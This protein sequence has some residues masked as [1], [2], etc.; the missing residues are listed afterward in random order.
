VKRKI[1]LG[2]L[3][4]MHQPY[5]RDPIDDIYILP[6]VRLHAVNAYYTMP[7]FASRFDKLHTNFNLVPSLIEQLEDYA[8]GR[9][10]DLYERYSRLAPDALDPAAKA[11]IL[12]NFFMANWETMIRPNTRYNDLLLKRGFQ[13]HETRLDEVSRNFTNQDFT[14]LQTW[15]N[16][17]WIGPAAREENEDIGKLLRKGRFF[18]QEE[19][20]LVLDYHYDVIRKVLPAYRE[21]A[22]QGLAELNL[23]PFYHPI[24]PLLCDSDIA[25]EA[26]PGVKLPERFSHQEDAAR[27]IELG[28]E[29]FER[30]LGRRPEGMWPSEGS[31]SRAVAS[32]ASEAGLKW[33]ATDEE[34]LMKS[35]P[36][37]PDR[38]D[39]IHRPYKI[40]TE[41]GDIAIFFR[42]KNLSDLLG[43]T[44]ARNTPEAAV[45]DFISHLERISEAAEKKK[46]EVFVSV[47]LD[48]ENPW[49]YY[50]NNGADFLLR[51][52][53]A[54]QKTDWIESSTFSNFLNDHPPTDSLDK[55]APGSWISGNFDIWIG[56]SEANTAWDALLRSRKL[57]MRTMDKSQ[58][59][60]I[61]EVRE[62]ILRSIYR[63]EGSDWFW[64][65]DDDFSSENEMEFDFLFRK[66]L[67]WAFHRL[68]EQVP[69][70]LNEP[71]K[72][73]Q[74][75]APVREPTDFI[76][77]VIDGDVTHYYEW[78]NAG[79]YDIDEPG[80]AMFD[81]QQFLRRIHFGFDSDQLYL[82]FDPLQPAIDN[83]NDRQFTVQV[84]F[85]DVNRM[86]HFKW[87]PGN[88]EPVEFT[89]YEPT[90]TG[91]CAPSK[92]YS[93]I[94]S[95]K[96]IE[97]S[98]PIKD[99]GLIPGDF[100]RMHVS[101]I[102][103]GLELKRYPLQGLISF[104]IPDET[105]HLKVWSV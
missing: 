55:L 104:E 65:Y 56:K 33:I 69:D 43:F 21:L 59:Q 90:P 70:F 47:I 80:G 32:M 74:D 38:G 73:S 54:I 77:P 11:F 30:A 88:S 28:I 102:R 64:W 95:G 48:G 23:S 92:T 7:R 94:S 37:K 98:I 22:D 79:G 25:S 61:P 105:F 42:D 75:I 66:H 13:V 18:T 49:E 9:A 24:L 62:E 27:H 99:I 81:S 83:N 17:A 3:W 46:G 82:R 39:V 50:E 53:E 8:E 101:I 36:G 97:L 26:H 19:R 78:A 63:A 71:I 57:L 4:H 29:T 14:D 45:E 52:F 44:Y 91:E 76:Q 1:H 10:N 67:A 96:I 60:A 6:W 89:L 51:F 85:P 41:T 20:D 31:V 34:I 68:G 93:T 86:L 2:F 5:Y 84:T 12:R 103:R 35:L 72:A 100:A 87:Y 16:L 40:D 15:F 58:V